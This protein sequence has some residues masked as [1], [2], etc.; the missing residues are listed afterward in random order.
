MYF[1]AG[2]LF[3]GVLFLG[4]GYLYFINTNSAA[5]K[6]NVV[7]EE[8]NLFPQG[9][10]IIY[11]SLP[12]QLDFAGEPVPLHMP[13]VKE[14]L[15]RELIINTYWHS[16]TL[17]ALKRSTRFFP[18]IEPILK[19][20]AI[21]DDFKYLAVIESGLTNV[22]SSA[23]ATG[24]WQLLKEP[25]VLYGLEVNDE[26][27]ER[28]HL[29]KST[30][31]ACLYL[32]Q[33][34]SIFNNWTLAAA[35]YNMGMSGVSRQIERQFTTDYYELYLNEETSRYISRVIALKEIMKN[36]SV[37]GFAV[38]DEEF[39]SPYEFYEIDITSPVLDLS[40]YSRSKG[41]SY[42]ILKIYNPWLRDIKISKR[43]KSYKIKMPV[44]R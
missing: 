21:P 29:E 38:S 7:S 23:G 11:P 24:I 2:I 33:A 39:Y 27:D 18:V 1:L 19:R 6:V 8:K 28:Y 22:V 10:R 26:I 4:A 36:P 9:Y 37:Y 20:Y 30:E 42:K 31:A 13:D 40:S 15:E 34:Y 3:S 41:L 5:G 44:V 43:G 12:G 32:L 14:R 35:S 17:L 25:A 16:F